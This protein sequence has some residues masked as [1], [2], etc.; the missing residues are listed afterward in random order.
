MKGQSPFVHELTV[1]TIH[2]K[3]LTRGLHGG[4][5]ETAWLESILHA[6]DEPFD[7]RQNA[8]DVVREV[9][10]IVVDIVAEL[11]AV[12]GRVRGSEWQVCPATAPDG[13][14][15]EV[16]QPPNAGVLLG[17]PE[18]VVPGRQNRGEGV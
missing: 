16:R 14:L 12:E 4:H 17:G 11:A 2:E 7:P 13:C 10:E 1:Q 8:R 6:E 9:Q 3:T 5:D 15:V 18:S